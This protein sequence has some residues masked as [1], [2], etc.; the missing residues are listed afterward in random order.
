MA[1]WFKKLVARHRWP[2][3]RGWIV[4]R[5]RIEPNITGEEKVNEMIPNDILL[6][7]QISAQPIC[8]QRGVIQQ[9][10]EA[11]ARLVAKHQA[12]RSLGGEWVVGTRGWRRP[13]EHGPQ[14][15]LSRAHRGSQRLCQQS[16]TLYGPELGLVVQ[17]SVLVRLLTVEWGGWCL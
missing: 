12:R 14:N 16:Q 17:L 8:H 6:Y 7:S 4:Q 13:Q 9:L 5:S 11:D 1:Q 15:Q 3:T 10:M 2:D